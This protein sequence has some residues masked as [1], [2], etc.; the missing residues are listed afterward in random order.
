VSDYQ[1]AHASDTRVDVIDLGVSA[2]DIVQANSTDNLHPD[3]AGALLLAQLIATAS[4]PLISGLLQ[5]GSLSPASSASSSTLDLA[6][7]VP[8]FGIA[9]YSY[10]WYRSTVPGFTPTPSTLIAGATQT[11]LLNT[12]LVPSTTYYYQVVY[13]DSTHPDQSVSSGQFAFTTT[14]LATSLLV[15]A[16]PFISNIPSIDMVGASFNAIVS[17]NGD[18]AVSVSSSTPSR[19][20]VTGAVPVVV[21]FVSVGQ[22]TLIA[23]V[24]QGVAYAGADGAAQSFAVSIANQTLLS[25]N[26]LRLTSVKG[27]AGKNLTLT[28]SGGSG[29][30]AVT[31]RVTSAGDAVCVIT[32]LTTI[33]A[34]RS[35]TCILIASKGADTTYLETNSPATVITFIANGIVAPSVATASFTYNSTVLSPSAKKYLRALLPKLTSSARLTVTGYA[36]TNWSLALSRAIRVETYMRSLVSHALHFTLAG[37]FTRSL[38]RVVVSVQQS[39]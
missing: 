31:Y 5:P 39:N 24:A 7:S 28:S 1:S 3:D 11:T 26:A 6:T 30:G 25:Q 32:H 10:Q 16:I 35:G 33:R 27:S 12:G 34:L 38:R 22:C 20:S 2:W 36:Y 19:C 8:T 23:H 18:G 13:R 15:P 4:A 17:T 14:D 29:S 37:V 21:T 9:P